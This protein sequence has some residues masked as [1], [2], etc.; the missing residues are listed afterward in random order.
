MWL[1][2]AI[3]YKH[4]S[5]YRHQVLTC[6]Y[7]AAQDELQLIVGRWDMLNSQSGSGRPAWI[8]QQAAVAPLRRAQKAEGKTLCC[9]KPGRAEAHRANIVYLTKRQSCPIL[10]YSLQTALEN[11]QAQPLPGSPKMNMQ[12]SF[13]SSSVC[14]NTKPSV[15]RRANASC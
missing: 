4:F 13:K 1:D 5:Q 15:R 7:C 2:E 6:S 8:T 9:Y 12:T 11:K 14:I 10:I 3:F